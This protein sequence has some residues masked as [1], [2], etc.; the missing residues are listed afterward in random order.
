MKKTI[1]IILTAFITLGFLVYFVFSKSFLNT[2][3]G[4]ENFV[5]PQVS[6]NPSVAQTFPSSSPDKKFT[7][8]ATGDVGLVRTVNYKMLQ[9]SVYY[10][11]EKTADILKS[12]D[13][14]LINLEG[15]LIKDCPVTNED[16]IFCGDADNVKGLT[17]SGID[18]AN[19]SNNHIYNYGEE[20]VEET[21]KILKANNIDY[22][23]FDS[24]LIK[25]VKGTKLAFLGYNLVG[26]PGDKQKIT[27][28]IK[29]AEKK[30]DFTVVSFHWG[31]EYVFEPN[32][33]QKEFA[34]L[35][36]DNGADLIIGNH[37][38]VVQSTE[39]YK[40]KLIVYAHGNFIF[41]QM[42]SEKTR[43]GV[44][45]KYYF[46]GNQLID[47]EFIPVYIEDYSQPQIVKEQE[48]KEKII[49]RLKLNS[50]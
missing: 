11:F 16:M 15:P 50:N 25:E 38:H 41:D 21:I 40:D 17:Y 19:L 30:A 45:G 26:L 22:S 9:N 14:S 3:S 23:G 5:S 6:D 44:I 33:K 4:K 18:I 1:L 29:E 35:A 46:N 13:L 10:P 48:K 2:D 7:I 32:W 37:P 28:Q 43:E 27:S 8:I 34:R 24:I 42:W 12:G 36:I 20:G 31:N 39:V 49:S 47:Y